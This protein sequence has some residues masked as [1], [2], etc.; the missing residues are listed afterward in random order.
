MNRKTVTIITPCYNGANFFDRYIKSILSQ[1]YRPIELIIINDGSTDDSEKKIKSYE[2]QLKDNE[3]N[4]IYLFQKNAGIGAAI[5]NGLNQM[6]GEFFTWID[7]DDFIL[8]TYL[9]KMVDFLEKYQDYGVVRSDGIVVDSEDLTKEL[10]KMADK[11]FDKFNPY[12]FENA[13]SGKNFH[14]GYSV[15]RTDCFIKANNGR[16][17]Y[18]SRQ[19]QNWQI[20]LPIFYNYKSGYIDEPL[21]VVC[22][23]DDSV[24]RKEVEYA[25]KMLQ[26]EEYRNILINVLN[27]LPMGDKDFIKY[28]KMVYERYAHRIFVLSMLNDDFCRAEREF[29]FLKQNRILTKK[30][31]KLYG[32]RLQRIDYWLYLKNKIFAKK[33]K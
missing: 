20:L 6:T 32:K 24:S 21:Y 16:N 3:I 12:M 1:T 19:G 30:E 2:I 13:I 28:K 11:N 7:V 31:K 14:F 23:R 5:Q 8:S 33:S 18:T 4:L 17:I 29:R 26:L 9:E 10:Y 25:P 27:K 22:E 15:V